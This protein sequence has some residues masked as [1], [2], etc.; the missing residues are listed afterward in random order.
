MK[1][2]IKMFRTACIFTIAMVVICG[3]A[4]PLVLTGISQLIFPNQANGSLLEV[5]GKTVGSAIVGQDFEDARFFKCRPSA[6]NYN[7]YSA[8][9]K[10]D[11]TYAGVAS[12]SNNYAPSNPALQERMEADI[13]AFLDA[14]PDV[15]REELPVDFITASGSGL[16]PHISVEAAKIQIAGI[17]DASGLSEAQVE[18]IIAENTSL[19]TLGVFGE[20][21]VNVL[22]CNIAIAQMINLI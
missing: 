2:T 19:K 6:Y 5:N 8:E 22:K 18:A 11:G 1:K 9:E 4:Y 3:F 14:N 17:V 21:T 12:G 10:A 20:E 15:T 13:Q 16:D 7:T